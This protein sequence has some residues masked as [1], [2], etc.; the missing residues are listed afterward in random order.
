MFMS[1]KRAC[2][3]VGVPSRENGIG[4]RGLVPGDVVCRDSSSMRLTSVGPL[5]LAWYCAW[6]SFGLPHAWAQGFSTAPILLEPDVDLKYL[7]KNYFRPPSPGKT[8]WYRLHTFGLQYGDLV[9]VRTRGTYAVRPPGETKFEAEE[10]GPF[11]GFFTGVVLHPSLYIPA[12]LEESGLPEYKTPPIQ[13]NNREVSTDVDR[14]FLITPAG[15][16]T[17]LPVGGNFLG[18][19]NPDPRV[20][21]KDEGDDFRVE[22]VPIEGARMSMEMQFSPSNKVTVGDPVTLTLVLTNTGTVPGLGFQMYDIGY[23]PMGTDTNRVM[24]V[25]GPTP[26]GIASIAPGESGRIQYTF[27]AT[28]PGTAA[29]YSRVGQTVCGDQFWQALTR[30]GELEIKPIVDVTPVHPSEEVYA[31]DSIEAGRES[32]DLPLRFTSDAAAL[33][34]GEKFVGAHWIADG[35]TPLLLR[36]ELAPEHVEH[37]PGEGKLSVRVKTT[38]GEIAGS[39]IQD[40][41]EVLEAGSWKPNGIGT[42]SKKEPATFAMLKAINADDLRIPN[43]LTEVILRVDVVDQNELTVGRTEIWVRRPPVVLLHGFNTNGEWNR[44]FL[45][46]FL[47]TRFFREINVARYGQDFTTP[48]PGANAARE[49]TVLA[50]EDLVTPASIAI[51]EALQ[52]YRGRWIFTRHDVVGHSQGGLLARML[53]AKRWSGFLLTAYRDKENFYRGRFHRVVTIG[54]PLNGT[55][56]LSY[57]RALSLN[58]NTIVMPTYLSQQIVGSGS[59]QDKFDPWGEQIAMVND[60][61]PDAAFY[62]D[63]AAKIHMI[64]TQILRGLNYST[65]QS[66]A[67]W[68][69]GLDRPERGE[70]VVDEGSD[71]IVDLASMFAKVPGAALPANAYRLPAEHLIAHAGAVAFQATN[72]QTDAILIARHV[73]Q[74]LDQDPDL[75]AADRTFAP[76][77]LPDRLPTSIKDAIAALARTFEATVTNTTATT[78]RSG[79]TLAGLPAL[80]ADPASAS[81]DYVVQVLQPEGRLIQ[82]R[83]YW[84]PQIFGTNG[85]TLSG[86]QVRPPGADPALVT[87]R[88]STGVYGDLVLEGAYESTNDTRVVLRPYLVA[89]LV[90]PGVSAAKFAVVPGEGARYPTGVT[91]PIEVWTTWS[92]GRQTL[93]FASPDRIQVSSSDPAVVDVSDPLHW[94]TGREGQAILTTT[95][96]GMTHRATWTVNGPRT[97]PSTPVRLSFENRGA[98]GVALLWPAS[99]SG[100][101]LQFSD[102]LGVEASWEAASDVPT[103]QGDQFVVAPKNL[104]AVRFYRLAKP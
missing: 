84:I 71:G 74:V 46:E 17:C 36:L 34:R 19:L 59:A 54:S 58:S 65:A 44:A 4:H 86:V 57:I 30:Y 64:G 39:P 94:R 55:R 35:V 37:Y 33:G 7:E 26:A 66:N 63:P 48:A 77:Q 61:N 103:P 42:V 101:Q 70:I 75:P 102:R 29:F 56:L 91:V 78:N 80:S 97:E 25:S 93:R 92:D 13:V 60:P 53:C 31:K 45:N 15:V 79:R 32:A 5:L 95:F 14:D 6:L 73:R 40:R 1:P 3:N 38:T 69:I 98:S 52:E 8:N 16:T 28:G 47:T 49:N 89:S 72:N 21:G 104:P 88:V 51:E 9:R 67:F 50:F 10:I 11:L 23:D 22:V 62:P 99:A 18:L 68:L 100:Y 82:G 85:V 43:G 2:A 87:L 81:G 76:I 12:P 41:V 27:R 90:P 83:T 96:E 20:L 24:E